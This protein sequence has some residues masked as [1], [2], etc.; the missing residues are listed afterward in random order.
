MLA[1][2]C[3]YIKEKQKKLAPCK[4]TFSLKFVWIRFCRAQAVLCES[5]STNT[6]SRAFGMS[7]TSLAPPT[8]SPLQRLQCAEWC[9]QQNSS[10]RLSGSNGGA[11]TL[12]DHNSE[13]FGEKCFCCFRW[14]ILTVNLAL[15][16][17]AC[18]FSTNK[19]GLTHKVM[20]RNP[21]AAQSPGNSLK[22]DF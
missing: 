8:D 6:W 11:A 15:Q 14:N 5:G 17:M 18:L 16:V 21:E 13:S 4:F 9:W 2:C 20:L 3:I 1:I 12:Q 10:D 22:T 7:N 19:H